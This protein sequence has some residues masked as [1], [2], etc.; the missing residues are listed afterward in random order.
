MLRLL[1]LLLPQLLVCHSEGAGNC[2]DG[3]FLEKAVELLTGSVQQRSACVQGFAADNCTGRLSREQMRT[4][5]GETAAAPATQHI[6][7]PGNVLP[8]CCLPIVSSSCMILHD[9]VAALGNYTV[10]TVCTVR[11]VAAT[12]NATSTILL[13]HGVFFALRIL[14]S[15]QCH[16]SARLCGAALLLAAARECQVQQCKVQL[17]RGSYSYKKEIPLEN[18]WQVGR[19]N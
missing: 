19:R 6:G 3:W 13:A 14:A 10:R 15:F 1:L 16:L 4:F 5:A 18:M 8:L 12:P 17:P 11:P 2:R 9:P 7:I